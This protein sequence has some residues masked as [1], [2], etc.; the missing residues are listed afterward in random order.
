MSK[1]TNDVMTQREAELTEKLA[2]MQRL[3]DAEAKR[4]HEMFEHVKRDAVHLSDMTQEMDEQGRD[5]W[6]AD[7]SSHLLALCEK[8]AEVNGLEQRLAETLA[9]L[10]A[11]RT[12]TYQ[13]VAR[14][15]EA[16]RQMA[17]LKKLLSSPDRLL[18]L[19]D[20]VLLAKL[21]QV[22]P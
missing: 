10:E 8:Q 4:F 7:A 2:E 18:T 3:Y 17:V 12:A 9:H 11:Q 15:H 5:S 21:K 1:Y 13:A 19:A 6:H 22:Q 14:E 20:L 16:K